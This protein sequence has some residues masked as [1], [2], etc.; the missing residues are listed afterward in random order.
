MGAYAAQGKPRLPSDQVG[1]LHVGKRE[2]LVAIFRI[3]GEWLFDREVGFTQGS[4][5]IH[6]SGMIKQI[7]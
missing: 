4:G 1:L 2:R 6:Q 7:A 3:V 5:K